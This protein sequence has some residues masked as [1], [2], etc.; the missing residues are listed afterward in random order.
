MNRLV[1]VLFFVVLFSTVAVGYFYLSQKTVNINPSP[2]AAATA[3]PTATAKPLTSA[4]IVAQIKKSQVDASQ[5]PQCLQK[6]L[7]QPGHET[8]FAVFSDAQTKTYIVYRVNGDNTL[9][10]G[11]FDANT[12]QFN[13]PEP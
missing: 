7:T 13:G 3:T 5:L 6:I 9:S 10:D 2:S 11:I 4:E 1:L 12:C 8:W